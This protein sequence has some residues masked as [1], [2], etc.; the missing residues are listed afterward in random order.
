MSSVE[1][2]QITAYMDPVTGAISIDQSEI[3]SLQNGGEVGA[4]RPFAWARKPEVREALRAGDAE[5]REARQARHMS[6]VQARSGVAQNVTAPGIDALAAAK[7]AGLVVQNQ[8]NGLGNVALAAVGGANT[9][10]LTDTV[11]R[12]L[13]I[14]GSVLDSDAS[15][16]IL[17]T[18][19]TVAGIPINVGSKGTPLG[20]F[21]R[22]ATRFGMEFAPRL[23]SVGQVVTV[24]LTNLDAGAAHIATGGVIVDEINPYAFQRI[25]ENTLLQ[26]VAG[27]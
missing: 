24:A 7:Q 18:S 8:Y 6:A 15:A 12:T 9:G 13:W 4:V 25:M 20:M 16:Y 1:L 21:A 10:T 23:A 5:V 14:R 19:V 26:S 2:G 27:Q 17:V 22:D 3:A 11:N